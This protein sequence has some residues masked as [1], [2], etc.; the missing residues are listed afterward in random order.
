MKNDSIRVYLV[1]ADSHK[2]FYGKA[3]LIQCG[4]G[5]YCESYNTPVASYIGG[6]FRR[7]WGGYSV[8]T[9]RHVNAFRAACGLPSIGKKEWD[10]LPVEA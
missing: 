10:A 2:S 4:G 7:S 3:V 8:T 9:M 5:L 6:V 1:P